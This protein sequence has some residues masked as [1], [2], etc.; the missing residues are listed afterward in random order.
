MS[1]LLF[2]LP[3]IIAL[4]AAAVF[5]L[6]K[7]QNKAVQF[8]YR[9]TLD[10]AALSKALRMSAQLEES[11]RYLC[12]LLAIDE[13]HLPPTG[14]WAASAD[15]LLL[16]AEDMLMRKPQVIVEFGSGLT[17]LVVAR[18]IELNGT[19]RL[20]SYDHDAGFT[21]ITRARLQR[22]GL[23]A[24]TEVVGLAPAPAGAKG[25]WYDAADLPSAIDLAIVD[26]PPMENHPET[27][28]GAGILVLPKLAPGGKLML[29]DASRPGERAIAQQWQ[30]R[31]PAMSFL[32][33]SNEKGALIVT[34][35][36][37]A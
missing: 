14:D 37:A 27:R 30:E 25:V 23:S 11:R 28:G 32:H 13:K 34:A 18:C 2:A 36:S 6:F 21:D 29:D 19:G 33:L 17:T 10:A 1:M 8:Y 12:H 35:P 16:V 20:F 24:P 15:F 9:D 22:L 7:M 26:G 31:F 5:L 3:L 4:L